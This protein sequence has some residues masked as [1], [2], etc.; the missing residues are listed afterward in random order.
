MAKHR[1]FGD[2]FDEIEPA[3]VVR[4]KIVAVIGIDDYQH[5]PRLRC[6]VNDATRVQEALVT[7]FGFEA[8]LRPLLNERATQKAIIEF[9]RDDLPDLLRPDDSLVLFFA[10]HGTT[11]KREHAP[12]TG[13]LA[14]VEAALPLRFSNLVD[15]EHLLDDISRLDAHHILVILDACNSGMALEALRRTR[16]IPR[17]QADLDRKR[18]RKVITSARGDQLAADQGPMPGNSLFTGTLI[19]GLVQ[20]RADFDKNGLVTSAELGLYVQQQVAQQRGSSQTPE[21]GVFGSD[22]LGE[23]VFPLSSG[24]SKVVSREKP[25]ISVPAARSALPPIAANA[26]TSGGAMVQSVLQKLRNEQCAGVALVAP[27]VFDAESIAKDVLDSARRPGEKLYPVHLVPPAGDVDE[28]A[29]FGKLLKDLRREIPVQWR[30]VVE[31]RRE[32]GASEQFGGAL[33]DLCAGPLKLEKR[34]IVLAIGGLEVIPTPL[35]RR[36]GMLMSRLVSDRLAVFVWGGPQLEDLQTRAGSSGGRFVRFV[37]HKLT[38]MR[39]EGV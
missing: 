16:Q 36:W 39:V 22:E 11:R 37:F 19:E 9:V 1:D 30:S 29:F 34:R 20:G 17:Y 33:E 32:L 27:R 14:P 24:A 25:A 26:E 7:F 10:G 8:P 3:A 38:V 2:A 23:L 35:L 18:S 12:D 21:Y 28:E 13:Y 15:M 4:R 31:V 5:L 6:A